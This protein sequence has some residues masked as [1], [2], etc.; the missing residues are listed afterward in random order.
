MIKIW[1][2]T[3]KKWSTSVGIWRSPYSNGHERASHNTNNMFVHKLFLQK[4][5]V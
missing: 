2:E 1:E 4:N 3:E 5:M